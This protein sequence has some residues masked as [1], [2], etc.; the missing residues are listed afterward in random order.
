MRK[1]KRRQLRNDDSLNSYYIIM[2]A[3]LPSNVL[4]AVILTK[5]E[6]PNIGRVL[7][8]LQWLPRVVV[9]D[10]FSSDSTKKV[11]QSFANTS[12]YTRAFDTHAMQWNY[13]LAQAEC[14]WILSLDA[15]YVLPEDF[16]DEIR[17][18]IHQVEFAAFNAPF[19]FLVFGKP[20]RGNNTTPRPVLFQK[21]LCS[22]YDEGHTQRLQV[23]GKTGTFIN[24]INHDDRKPLSRWLLNQANYSLKESTMLI[25]TPENQL[26]LISKIRKTKV[27]APFFIFFYCLFIKGLILDGWR[28]WHYTMQRT[29]VEILFAL[30]LVEH[31]K[32]DT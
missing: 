13:G 18:K 31:D 7:E 24:K 3:Y 5:N 10:S 2:T 26:S 4:Q 32:L 27:L 16:C 20:L 9:V 12:W 11:V 25:E 17:Q 21:A 14:Q 15:D 28:G 23:N 30:R 8:K 6:E 29:L 19:N 22:Y 1:T